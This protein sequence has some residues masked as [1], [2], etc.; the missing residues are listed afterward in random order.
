M[1]I[2]KFTDTEYL[3]ILRARE[4]LAS[5]KGNKYGY[6][7]EVSEPPKGIIDTEEDAWTRME[8]SARQWDTLNQLKAEILHYRQER[9]N[10]L[11]EVKKLRASSHKPLSL[12]SLKNIYNSGGEGVHDSTN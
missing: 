4:R 11:L 2:H 9:V 12:E 7:E 10:L 5:V 6:P 8:L 1:M 3:D